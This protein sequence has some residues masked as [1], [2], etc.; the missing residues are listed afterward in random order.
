MRRRDLLAGAA[1]AAV[2]APLAAAAQP[3]VP[4]VGYLSNRSQRRCGSL[5]SKHWRRPG[6]SSAGMSRSNT[7]LPRDRSIACRPWLPSWLEFR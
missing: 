3:G 5:S 4:I 7:A 2:L 6:S 1:A